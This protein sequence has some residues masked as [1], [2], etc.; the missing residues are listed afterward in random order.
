VKD[1]TA[2]LEKL[3]AAKMLLKPEKCYFYKEEVIFLSYV[4]TT[5]RLAINLKKIKVIL[6]WTGLINIKEL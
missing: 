4:V 3:E 5:I 6:E 2:I 1:V